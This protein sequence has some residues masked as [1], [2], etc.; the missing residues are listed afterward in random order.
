MGAPA[1]PRWTSRRAPKP[2]PMGRGSQ[3]AALFRC[4]RKFARSRACGRG[5]LL[6]EPAHLGLRTVYDIAG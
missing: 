5:R 4:M 3:D 1:R 6:G 2:A